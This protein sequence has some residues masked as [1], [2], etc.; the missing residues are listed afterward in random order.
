M[1][2]VENLQV[3]LK[4]LLKNLIW[5]VCGTTLCA[6]NVAAN[7]H[8]KTDQALIKHTSSDQLIQPTLTYGIHAVDKTVEFFCRNCGFPN[9]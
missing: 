9:S 7:I 2:I 3:L 4:L 1:F 5:G 6:D 8:V